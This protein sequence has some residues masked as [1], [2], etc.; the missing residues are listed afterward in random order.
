MNPQSDRYEILF[1]F[2]NIAIKGFNQQET[3]NWIIDTINKEGHAPGIIQFIFCDDNQLLKINQDYLN[4]N[5]L[6]DIVTFNYNDE[7]E[8]ISGDI[9][10]SVDRVRENAEDYNVTFIEELHRVIIHGILHLL[11]FDDQD[12]RTREAIRAKE[13]YYLS[14]LV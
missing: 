9:F 6:T 8:G 13:N 1:T 11:G 10:I 14:L 5:T 3:R 4:H 7:F 2:E 12:D